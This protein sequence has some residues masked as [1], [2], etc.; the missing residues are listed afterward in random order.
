[1]KKS[2]LSK[3][4]YSSIRFHI[5]LLLWLWVWLAIKVFLEWL[6][7]VCSFFVF[8]HHFASVS[9]ARLGYIHACLKPILYQLLSKR[10]VF[11]DTWLYH[12]RSRWQQRF[13]QYFRTCC[14]LGVG[15][16]QSFCCC[17]FIASFCCWYSQAYFDTVLLS[18]STTSRRC[19]RIHE[20]IAM[21]E[22]WH[23]SDCGIRN[24]CAPVQSCD[25]LSRLCVWFSL[26]ILWIP[27]SHK[28]RDGVQG[29]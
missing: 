21:L 17:S 1:M 22:M 2:S 13:L 11:K 3:V 28:A 10:M 14:W 27:S 24:S 7:I 12:S 9:W 19:P 18:L 25:R 4:E 16:R 5:S 15:V 6:P 23:V 20:W 29:S 26:L 8:R